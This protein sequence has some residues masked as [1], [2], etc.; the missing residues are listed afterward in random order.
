MTAPLGNDVP[1]KAAKIEGTDL[2]ALR[3]LIPVG[4]R[5]KSDWMVLVHILQYVSTRLHMFVLVCV[6]NLF[7]YFCFKL[8]SRS[9]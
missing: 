7:S 1:G 9:R 4:Q 8:S 2:L 5:M 3:P 6:V